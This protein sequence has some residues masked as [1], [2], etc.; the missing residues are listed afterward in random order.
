MAPMGHLNTSSLITYYILSLGRH[1]GT[2]SVINKVISYPI[3]AY[4]QPEGRPE[5]GLKC[6]T[7][8]DRIALLGPFST[9]N[10][11]GCRITEK[12]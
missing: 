7:G 5:Q 4:W 6:T 11:A 2:R 12:L 10:G 8:R 1:S 3:S 9:V